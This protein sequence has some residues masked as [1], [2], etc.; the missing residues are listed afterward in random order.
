M[1]SEARS[2]I[3]ASGPILVSVGRSERMRSVGIRERR[4]NLDTLPLSGVRTVLSSGNCQ[5]SF[6][7]FSDLLPALGGA[8]GASTNQATILLGD[9]IVQ[10]C[11]NSQCRHHC[12]PRRD[13]TVAWSAEN[14]RLGRTS[15]DYL[16]GGLRFE[17]LWPVQVIPKPG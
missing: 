13:R 14:T 8:A 1:N 4:L 16:G 17:V 7:S 15:V 11:G 10:V 3:S 5:T 12:C 9:G 6:S 2:A